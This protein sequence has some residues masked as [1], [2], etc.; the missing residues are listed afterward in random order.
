MAK[1][2]HEINLQFCDDMI[3][4]R[5]RSAAEHAKFEEY[6]SHWKTKVTEFQK[7]Y[8]EW[9][10]QDI[11]HLKQQ[12]ELFD[13]DK[14]CLIEFKEFDATM[15]ELNDQSSYEERFSYFDAVDDSRTGYINFEEFLK[16]CS[17]QH[18]SRRW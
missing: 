16:P 9:S 14:D 2:L 3:Q 17:L 8:P 18:I 1:Q 15:N 12:F 5:V 13:K 11:T 6:Q 7:M 10:E 4:L